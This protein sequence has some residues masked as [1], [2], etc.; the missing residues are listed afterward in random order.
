MLVGMKF[1]KIVI[2]QSIPA[3]EFQSGAALLRRIQYEV[4]Q[5]APWLAVSLVDCIGESDY[6]AELAKLAH[7]AKYKD[8]IPIIHTEIHGDDLGIDF[9]DGTVMEWSEVEALLTTLNIASG[10]NLVTI[11]SACFGAYYMK[12]LVAIRAASCYALVAPTDKLQPNEILLPFF[13]FYSTLFQKADLGLAIGSISNFQ[14]AQ[15]RWIGKTAEQL[16]EEQINRYIDQCCTEEYFPTRLAD[17]Q[18]QATADGKEVDVYEL[19]EVLRQL[20]RDNISHGFFDTY[21]SIKEIPANR[22]RFADLNR[23]INDRLR[24]LVLSGGYVL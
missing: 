3:N 7:N 5:H 20:N 14:L 1:T 15:G 17:L 24:A 13:N 2:L 10:F 23:R 9:S 8:E 12:T 11:F 4:Q 16:F 21:F 6:R 22:A 18:R 19:K